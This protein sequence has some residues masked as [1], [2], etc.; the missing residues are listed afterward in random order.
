MISASALTK[1]LVMAAAILIPVIV[2]LIYNRYNK[3]F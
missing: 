3:K 1:L 2:R